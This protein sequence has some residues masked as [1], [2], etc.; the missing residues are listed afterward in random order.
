MGNKEVGVKD[1]NK[2]LCC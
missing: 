1:S 2:R